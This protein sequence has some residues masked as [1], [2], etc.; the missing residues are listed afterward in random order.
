MRIDQALAQR[1]GSRSKAQDAIA[2]S[3]VFVN[4]KKV[5]KASYSVDPDQD[6][7]E[8]RDDGDSFVSRAGGKLE[9]AIEE[10]GIDLDGCT[11]ADI[12]ASTGGFTQC[13][14]QH[15]ARKVYAIDVGHLQLAD[16]LKNDPRIVNMEKTNA[17]KI[18]KDWFEEDI[19]FVCMDVSFIS[20]LT[21]LEPLLAAMHPKSMVIL[22][23]PQFECG[24]DAINKK[25]IVRNEK[26]GLQAMEKVK[27]F[28]K[29]YYE[30]VYSM[31]SPIKGRGGNQEYLLYAFGK[32]RKP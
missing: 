24:P 21:I 7:I 23:K 1:L 10:F 19:D 11:A 30:R 5:T 4:Q 16:S 15:G 18:S 27:A 2:Q 29:Q 12:G 3:R 8:V 13:C 17:R 14:L 22:V 32:E 20:S 25:G 6:V 9:A 26:L 31:A 28:L